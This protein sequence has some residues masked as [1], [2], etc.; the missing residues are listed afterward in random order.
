MPT[1]E[2]DQLVVEEGG[3]IGSH[4]IVF[5]HVEFDFPL[6]CPDREVREPVGCVQTELRKV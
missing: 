3:G 4:V 6:E 5:R 2:V 1:L